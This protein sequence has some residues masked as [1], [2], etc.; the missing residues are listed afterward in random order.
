ML[1][2]PRVVVYDEV[3]ST[4]DIVHRLGHDGAD[5]GTL[6]IAD[7]QTAGRGRMGRSWHSEPGR[8]I[9]LT[10]LERPLETEALSVLSLRVALALAPALDP[11]ANQP[12]R[13]KWP[14]D[15]YAGD[16]K[17]AGVLLEARWRG[18]HLD[19]LAA[20]VGVNVKAPRQYEAASLAP[21]TDRIAVLRAVVPRLRRALG[22]TGPLTAA[23]RS[24]F[25]ARDL[26]VGRECE[27]PA[28]GRVA[29]IDESGALLVDTADGRAAFHGGSLLLGSNAPT[30]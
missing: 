30:R 22:T 15:V 28:R 18:P 4:L 6:V 7:A 14:N 1:S 19:W 5:A 25:A 10:L 3:P 20:G 2:L 23:E 26:A 8:G 11:F 27:S 21:G 12:V 13:L 17:L 29:G 16:R 24:D 9:W